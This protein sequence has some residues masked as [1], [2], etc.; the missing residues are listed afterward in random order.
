MSHSWEIIIEALRNELQEYGGLLGFYEEQQANLL[1]RDADAVLHLASSIESQVGRA[2]QVRE[3]RERLVRAFAANHG[4]PTD[5]TLR[6]LLSHFPADVQPL[7]EAL[8]SE[9]NRLIHRIRRGARQNQ[10]LLAR[11]VETHEAI[12]RLVRP[13]S[14]NKTY[15]ARGSVSVSNTDSAWQAAG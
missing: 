9:I 3:T 5:T 6:A 2:Q 12:V 4:E 8:V 7:I 1:R 15:S 13:A 11:A 14:L 10:T